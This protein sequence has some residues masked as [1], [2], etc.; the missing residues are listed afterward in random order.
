MTPEGGKPPRPGRQQTT[1]FKALPY[2]VQAAALL[3][4]GGQGGEPQR[5]AN[6]R[7]WAPFYKP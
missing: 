2:S 3:Q 6:P 1:S 5:R 4:R 7:L